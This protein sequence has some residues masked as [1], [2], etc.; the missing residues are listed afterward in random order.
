LIESAP[1][2]STYTNISVSWHF[3]AETARYYTQD[4][5]NARAQR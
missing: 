2:D 5:P 1:C 4:K 3:S